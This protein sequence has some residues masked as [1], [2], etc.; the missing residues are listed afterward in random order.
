MRKLLLI[1]LMLAAA[2]NDSTGPGS[3][4]QLTA[5]EAAELNR[6]VF[7]AVSGVA[8]M[9]PISGSLALPQGIAADRF[10]I[11]VQESQPCENGGTLSVT[12]SVTLDINP[13]TGANSV[14]AG[15]RAV[16]SACAHRMESGAVISITGDPGI[17]VQTTMAANARALTAFTV[18][19]TG[20]FTWTRGGASGR[21]TV[22]VTA[23][24][25]SA[26]T[27]IVV[28]GTFCGFPVSE[29]L[30]IA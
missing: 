17:D 3:D 1:P 18:T 8:N 13:Q 25:N 30:P 12:G 28:S 10:T 29:T 4:A 22:N 24:M 14:N 26:A 11:P 19:E 21:C 16:P 5:A 27:Q 20:A 2:C 7:G 6:A 15:I 23:Q 9:R